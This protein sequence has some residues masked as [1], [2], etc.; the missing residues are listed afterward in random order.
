MVYF[1]EWPT[2]MKLRFVVET[3]FSCSFCFY[4]FYFGRRGKCPH[5]CCFAGAIFSLLLSCIN[6]YKKY[7]LEIR[8]VMI[9]VYLGYAVDTG[10][11]FIVYD[12]AQHRFRLLYNATWI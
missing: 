7:E 12:A 4:Y 8:G 2:H 6:L 10:I 11:L 1:Q 5:C 9:W 3:L